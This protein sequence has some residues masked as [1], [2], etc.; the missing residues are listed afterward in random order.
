MSTLVCSS[1]NCSELSWDA[2]ATGTID[3][4]CGESDAPPLTGCSGKVKK[5]PFLL[6]DHPN[7]FDVIVANLME[8]SQSLSLSFA[9]NLW[10]FEE[11]I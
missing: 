11:F 1:L 3:S 9:C 2:K 7:R 4:V 6:D 5:A 10:S 8:N